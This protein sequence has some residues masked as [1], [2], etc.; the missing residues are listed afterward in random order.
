MWLDIMQC[1]AASVVQGD[2]KIPGTLF[3]VVAVHWDFLF[4]NFEVY[5]DPKTK[6]PWSFLS[7]FGLFSGYTQKVGPSYTKEE[8]MIKISVEAKPHM[9]EH[10]SSQK[11]GDFCSLQDEFWWWTTEDPTCWVVDHS[12]IH[13]SIHPSIHLFIHSFMHAC[14]HACIHFF[15]TCCRSERHLRI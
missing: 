4:P 10:V 6:S 12:F 13:P 1:S 5:I 11:D 2:G 14:M 15:K 7:G 8:W 9:D 3:L